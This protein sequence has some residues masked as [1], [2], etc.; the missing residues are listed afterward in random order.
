MGELQRAVR[1]G[2]TVPR[3]TAWRVLSAPH[4][5]DDKIMLLRLLDPAVENLLIDVGGNSGYWSET[6]L[7]FFPNSRVIAFEPIE[8]EFGRYQQRFRDSEKVE[9]HNVGLSDKTGVAT[10][11]LAS[12]SAHSSLHAYATGQPGLQTNPEGEE[13]IR[14]IPLDAMKLWERPA[15]RTFLKVDVQGHELNVLQG[16]SQTLAHVDVLQVECSFLP[17]YEHVKPSFPH[18]A[19][20]L[21][22]F[23]I[24]PAMFRNYGTALG[25]YAWEQDV[26]FCKRPLLDDI[27]GW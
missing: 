27:W 21:R 24:Y 6:Y 11:H 26:I 18:V 2:K 17:E 8:K 14:L 15:A 4:V 5:L 10:L 1:A 16:A 7:E 25:P 19:A 23:D 9:V 22:D 3:G 20:Y 13:E 12:C